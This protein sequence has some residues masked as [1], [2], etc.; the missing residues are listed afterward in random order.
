MGLLSS[1]TEMIS[2]TVDTAVDVV[3]APVKAGTIG[4][5]KIAEDFENVVA[6]VLDPLNLFH[7]D[8]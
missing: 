7:D 6:D 3:S 2:D 8:D 5:K 1:I 4:A